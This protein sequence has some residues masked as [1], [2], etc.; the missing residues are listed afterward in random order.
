[1]KKKLQFYVWVIVCVILLCF[2]CTTYA[3]QDRSYNFSKNYTLSGEKANDLVLVAKAQLGKTQSNLGYSEAWCANFVTDCARLAGISEDVI[4]YN[5]SGRAYVPYLYDYM[6]NNCSAKRVYDRQPGDLL[7]YY[8]NACGGFKHVAIVED[9]TYSI[10][11]NYWINGI[12]Q[13]SRASVYYDDCNHTTTNGTI[14]RWYVRPNFNTTA[15]IVDASTG[16]AI[17]SWSDEYSAEKYNVRIKDSNGVSYDIWNVIEKNAQIVLPVGQYTVYIDYIKGSE[18]TK[19]TSTEFNVSSVYNGPTTSELYADTS[20]NSV[21]F[22]WSKSINAQGYNIRIVDT[23]GVD[24]S[25]WNKTE[26]YASVVLPLGTYYA[27]VDSYKGDEVTKGKKICFTVTQS[28]LDI[29]AVTPSVSVSNSTVRL[30]W[31]KAKNAT[32]YSVRIKRTDGISYDIWSITDT[33]ADI[34]LPKGEYSVYIDSVNDYG[35]KGGATVNFVVA[36]TIITLKTT[37]LKQENTHTINVGLYNINT[38]CNILV[39][40]YKNNRFVT[41]ENRIYSKENETFT[42]TGDID[43][44]KVMLWESLSTMLPLCKAEVISEDK[45]VVQ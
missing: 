45:F 34:V 29:E 32:K 1:M 5:Y 15:P 4:P 10:E 27:Y 43:E 2:N 9:S 25:L 40:G 22:T 6:I 28:Y 35:F 44:I 36:E 41:V 31:K 13:V 21:N 12:S 18:Y 30:T 19:G 11:G 16:K 20:G 14:E 33:T 24:Y 42:A 17:I 3:D 38:P 8:C 23:N 39:A 7:F 26:T 37:V